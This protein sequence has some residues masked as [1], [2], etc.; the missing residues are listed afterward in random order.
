[1]GGRGSMAA[2]HAQS[3]AWGRAARGLA[4]GGVARGV[5]WPGGEGGSGAAMAAAAA[6]AL[7][8]WVSG[9]LQTL[10]GLSGRHV[11]AFLVALARR[12]RSVEELLE[13]LR[14][15]E[16]L[17]VEEPRVRAFARELWEK[18]RAGLGGGGGSG[19][20]FGRSGRGCR[21]VGGA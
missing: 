4:G 21:E 16:A 20:G 6:A 15:T 19:R 5:R 8:R 18:V 3:A 11:P 2:A 13:R 10:L 7:E 17:R 1:M 14:E 12:S 9:E